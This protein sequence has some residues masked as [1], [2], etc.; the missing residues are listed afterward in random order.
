MSCLA[1]VA[2]GR[3]FEPA[4]RV[5]TERW[6]LKVVRPDRLARQSPDR[7]EETVRRFQVEIQAAA[8]L[9]HESIV[10][11]YEVG[12]VE[13]HPF[14]SMRYLEGG[15]LDSVIRQG[16][17]DGREAASVVETIARAVQHAHSH[18]V[19]HRDLKP[20][21]ILLDSH[22]HPYVG[23]F[24]LA[25]SREIQAELTLPGEVIGTPAYM[26]PEQAKGE[27]S[28]GIAADIYGL[29]AT[30]Y[31]L[32]TG[33][34]PF[35]AA[36]IAETQRQV[37]D[38]NPVPPRDLNPAI[39]RDLETIC[40]KCLEKEPR[41]RYGSAEEVAEE[42]ARFR[43]RRPIRARPIGRVQRF[44]RWCRRNP[45]DAGL[46][47]AVAVS[48]L[49]GV[50]VS[51]WF[52][53]QSRE[54][55][56]TAMEY[57]NTA[58]KNEQEATD[59][60]WESYLAQARANRLSRRVG[61]QFETLE[62]IKAAMAIRPSSNME[63]TNRLRN[64]AIACMALPDL[65]FER[66]VSADVGSHL[67]PEM[68]SYADDD[69][70]GN[71]CIRR[72]SD[73]QVV[74]RFPGPGQAAERRFSSDGRLL[75]VRH[76]V[77]KQM[78]VLFWDLESR[79]VTQEIPVPASTERMFFSPDLK[80][81][82]VVCG[83]ST[84]QNYRLSDGRLVSAI[85][86]ASQA[87][88]ACFTPMS[89]YIAV[90]CENST[91]QHYC[92]AD[93]QLAS[94]I[95]FMPPRY[96][97]QYDP[98]GRLLAV[99]SRKDRKHVR[100]Y[101]IADGNL[102]WEF[103]HPSFTWNTSWHPSGRLLAVPS[104]D[105]CV[106]VW[107]IQTGR[108]H[109]VLRGHEAEVIKAQFNH[110][111][112]LLVTSGWEPTSRIWDPIS[113]RMLVR[114]T[115]TYPRFS[116]D[117]LRLAVKGN[118]GT[119]I[120]KIARNKCRIYHELSFGGRGPWSVDI[121][122]DSRLLAGGCDR[123]VA[124]WDVASSVEIA[125]LRLHRSFF[126]QFCPGGKG[127][128][129]KSTSGL[130]Y[131]PTRTNIG[132]ATLRIGP[133]CRLS[134][135]VS[136]SN[137][138]GELNAAGTT[139]ASVSGRNEVVV[140]HSS[141]PGEPVYL[142][143][144]NQ[145]IFVSVSPDGRWVVTNVAR[146][147]KEA[148]IWNAHT[149]QL[150]KSLPTGG[151][152]GRLAFSPDGRRLVVRSSG[153]F[154][155]WEVGTWDPGVRISQAPGGQFAFSPDGHILAASGHE[156]AAM[157]N[158][159][160]GE[161]LAILTSP[162]PVKPMAMC[163]SPDGH[164]LAKACVNHKLEVW[165]LGRIRQQLSDIGLDWDMP[166]YP[167]RASQGLASPL[168]VEVVTE[169]ESPFDWPA[170]QLYRDGR[171]EAARQAAEEA[172]QQMFGGNGYHWFLM[173]QIHV[174]LDNLE[175]AERWFHRGCRWVENEMPHDGA[176]RSLRFETACL[177]LDE[178]QNADVALP[179][180]TWTDLPPHMNLDI[181]ADGQPAGNLSPGEWV[182]LMPAMDLARDRIA[183]KWQCASGKIKA[184]KSNYAQL[185]LPVQV[186]GSYELEVHLSRYRD[187]RRTALLLPVGT[188]RCTLLL[189]D[190]RYRLIGLA[191][192]AGRP[193][194][195]NSTSV[196]LSLK[197]GQKHIVQV[198]VQV[199]ENLATI[200]VDLD[201][202]S[203]IRWAGFVSDLHCYRTWNF[204]KI[205]RPGLGADRC[206]VT[207][208]AVRFRPTS[209]RAKLLPQ[210]TITKPN[211]V[212][213]PPSFPLG[214]TH[215]CEYRPLPC[216]L[217]GFRFRVDDHVTA[218]QPIYVGS[219]GYS[220]GSLYGAGDPNQE[221]R[222]RAGYAVSGIA[223]RGDK[224]VDGI[225]VEFA[226]V[227]GD[228]LDLGDSYEGEW[229]GREAGKEKRI[230][231]DGDPIVGIHGIADESLR[232]LGLVIARMPE[233]PSPI[234]PPDSLDSLGLQKLQFDRP[235]SGANPMLDPAPVPD[236]AASDPVPPEPRPALAP[237]PSPTLP[238]VQTPVASPIV[239]DPPPSSDS[240]APKN[241][242]EAEKRIGEL[243]VERRDTLREHEK[244]VR[245]MLESGV[246]RMYMDGL[247]CR[248]ARALERLCEAEL[249][250]C[251]P[252]ED[253]VAACEE[254]VAKAKWF[255]D[256]MEK[257]SRGVAQ[258]GSVGPFLSLLIA[259][260][261]RLEAEIFVE[262]ER[263]ERD[264]EKLKSLLVERRDVLVKCM[265]SR[266]RILAGGV[267]VDRWPVATMRYLAAARSLTEAELRACTTS[268]E[269][270]AAR[271][272]FHE[273]AAWIE[274]V[275]EAKRRVQ[276][277]G[278]T[279]Q[280]CTSAKAAHLKA[281]IELLRERI[282]GDY[283]GPATQHLQIMPSAAAQPSSQPPVQRPGPILPAPTGIVPAPAPAPS[284]PTFDSDPV[285]TEPVD[286]NT[287]SR[288]NSPW[289]PLVTECLPATAQTGP[290]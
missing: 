25:K 19:I 89:R 192:V 16:P 193:L 12:Q 133:P 142:R 175:E 23:D 76:V 239:H 182:D 170:F 204:P 169:E 13:G 148:Q 161:Q 248:Y 286:P 268:A 94:T 82:A 17:L 56:L 280:E 15:S 219:K 166:P 168:T 231:G 145:V 284:S 117:D 271:Q 119:A 155:F 156:E 45:L 14:F 230:C 78:R 287:S 165:D 129:T 235:P 141:R 157:F 116:V 188:N 72:I 246:D 112:D 224:Q 138:R 54:N 111:G 159:T 154:Q 88:L 243:L 7:M 42:L 266:E 108:E 164:Y 6:R 81:F 242:E 147:D 137:P 227:D 44:W 5:L 256:R 285:P 31:E 146:G 215:I 96:D 99:Q 41:N 109:I 29:G 92:P 79:E 26:A 37:I 52:A 221:V 113:G 205:G 71:V 149:G 53:F 30:L 61:Q 91:I 212:L 90:I 201:G 197:D 167:P 178:R 98:T 278:G 1:R 38:N 127:L 173:A 172:M 184:E 262:Q 233:L 85:E 126:A 143:P 279:I 9:E 240:P 214:D 198:R 86:L 125:N 123:G 238:F 269:R 290:S 275:Y 40:L 263:T 223:L 195:E 24:G 274:E 144:H 70:Q 110:S 134:G 289:F 34:P 60:L 150:A 11:V 135:S 185:V 49:V 200:E 27:G 218:I 259:N 254:I 171:W 252:P 65:R 131:W 179:D 22:G 174:Q 103:A 50:V 190:Q 194:Q 281:E 203:S 83:R 73:D 48:L 276:A 153:E 33:R 229:F 87:Q 139:I 247:V 66:Q 10:P 120:W 222:A 267:D 124:L 68:E 216:H 210:G 260:T 237:S 46:S 207:F 115:G 121:G 217:I 130:R 59:K 105:C 163:F 140:R 67:H 245:E 183:G 64:E 251:Q 3:C 282:E 136:A 18:G 261:S 95:K 191:R 244:C 118:G 228:R 272:R 47:V 104:S 102:V 181:E 186:F 253:R 264:A 213:L 199:Y 196:P 177:I 209:G 220:T 21:N 255:E 75:A 62:V 35:R 187:E 283:W 162:V 55:E 202:K 63:D 151:T 206:R 158:V 225:R 236:Y 128:V 132:T 208:H 93:G 51:G 107:N 232:A 180:N 4:S 265:N 288:Q 28:V 84:L 57:A 234:I 241:K 80:S 101:D 20:R 249:E 2:W 226:R 43:Q 77:D 270:I 114:L 32:I 39:P 176:L 36:T 211:Y 122:P 160:T 8:Q 257:E 69:E 258:R 58:S 97:T 277:P 152:G 273:S 106:H 74:A 100:V 250:L 189:S